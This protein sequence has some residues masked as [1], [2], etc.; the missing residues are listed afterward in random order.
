METKKFNIVLLGT[1]GSG[2]GTQAKMIAEKYNLKHVSTGELFRKEISLHNALGIQAQSYIDR[3]E[4]CPDTLTLDMLN[5]YLNHFSDA[6]GYIL[7]GVPR[8]I[9]Q[10]QLLDGVG[11][12]KK[13]TIDLV[14]YLA[15][16]QREI[17]KRMLERAKL[18]GRSDDTPEVIKNR[19]NN[20]FAQTK[21][22]ESYY[23]KDKI[24]RIN[25]MNE[26][27]EVFKDVCT[28]IDKYIQ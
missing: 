8:T 26:P 19:I 1:P 14:I 12:D 4:L 17:E 11:Y 15:V 23:Q 27:E 28:V 6:K 5:D 13:I 18:E 24:F 20:Y 2:K 21:P 9:K 7:D 16:N 22:L 25:G 10:A 3:G